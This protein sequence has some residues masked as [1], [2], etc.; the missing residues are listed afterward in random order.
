MTDYDW[1][2]LWTLD[3]GRYGDIAPEALHPSGLMQQR[4]WR[5]GECGTLELWFEPSGGSSVDKAWAAG[6][7]MQSQGRLKN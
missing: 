7:A 3:K 5:C 6:N 1:H 4:T 2:P